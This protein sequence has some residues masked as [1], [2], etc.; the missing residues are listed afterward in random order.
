MGRSTEK[1]DMEI[2]IELFEKAVSADPDFAEA[3]AGLARTHMRMRWFGHDTS[4]ERL[5]RAKKAVDNAL[6]LKPDD[7][8]VREANGYYYYYGFRDYPRALDEFMFCQ[9]KEPRNAS[10]NA[11]IAYVQRRLGRFEEARQNQEIAFQY[12]PRS[13]LLAYEL[14]LTYNSLRMYNK[15]ESYFDCAIS[16][17][18]DLTK[19]YPSKAFTHIYKTGTTENA[20][21]ILES[22]SSRVK[23]DRLIWTLTYFNIYDGKYQEALDR[24]SS[25]H[26]VVWEGHQ[27]YTPKDVIR[28]RIY[29]LKGQP[30]QARTFYRQAQRLLEQKANELTDDPRIYAELGKVYGHLGFM[31]E[32]VREGEKAVDLLPVSRDAFLGPKYIA[33]LAEIYTIVGEYETALDKLEYLL[34]IPAGI[35]IGL[36][37]ID[38]VWDPLRNH[39][40]FQKLLEE[41]K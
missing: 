21:R 41:R 7:P 5:A 4:P 16:L 6:N 11:N 37:K 29:D 10:Y 28:G 1:N 36:L 17:A 12:D 8:V 40:R 31:N 25:F 30:D 3:Y 24:L 22:A 18:P 33:D 14:G 9:R 32:A 39:P 13:N 38:P 35:H 23:S 20:R 19:G 27:F 34:E 2:A 26:E 15:A